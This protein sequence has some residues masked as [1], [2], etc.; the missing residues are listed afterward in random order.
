MVRVLLLMVSTI[1][2]DEELLQ[3]LSRGDPGSLA[4]LYRRHGGRM[5]GFARRF[6]GSQGSAEDVVVD[7]MRRWLER[8][9]HVRKAERLTAF[10]ASSVYHAAVDWIREDR[11]AQG[12]PPRAD[13]GSATREQAATYPSRKRESLRRRLSNALGLLSNEDR[14]LLET[15]YG[16]ALTSD[17]CMA[18]LQI[19]RGAF[20]QRL[21]RARS[22]LARLL[23]AEDS[24]E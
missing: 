13:A 3:A 24:H 11:A 7:L 15:H 1:G 4:L 18:L 23:E 9:P 22:R 20:H 17:E 21:H 8:P 14:T 10:L 16:Q 12:R 19:S 5:V 2:S 6:V